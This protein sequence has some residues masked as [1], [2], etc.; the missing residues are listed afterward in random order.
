MDESA[1]REGEILAE[2]FRVERL[3]G[4]G[5]M[6][7]V[8]RA[9]D[10]ETKGHAAIKVLVTRQH[11]RRDRF[12]REASVL[13]RL[14]H[15]AIVR[16]LAHGLTA[17]QAPFLAMEWLDGEDL[18][19]RLTR[20]GLAVE[21]TLAMMHRVCDGLSAAHQLGITH[22]DVKPS[23]LFL[24]GGDVQRVKLLDFGVAREQ[25]A[26]R[27]STRAGAMVGTVGYMAPEQA[28]GAPDV[29][30]RADVFALGCVMFECLTGQPAFTGQHDIAVLA[31]VL[32][33][34]PP[35][36]S[37][38]QPSVG[39]DLD[40]LVASQLA[41]DKAQRPAD[42]R[43]VLR[44]L[45][46]VRI[47]PSP[48]TRAR[49]PAK[50]ERLS[51]AERRIVSVVL[52]RPPGRSGDTEPP[53]TLDAA[54]EERAL[55]R[56]L[57]VQVTV[58][59]GGGVLIVLGADGTRTAGDQ[60]VQAA[61][62]A[63]RLRA[64]RP[65]LTVA[66]ATGAVE[67]DAEV[68]VGAAID[69]A[70]AAIQAA[71]L[72][73]LG[74]VVDD[75][76]L[77]LL[78]GHFDHE[79]VGSCNALVI[80]REDLRSERLLLGKHM[81]CV[82]REKDLVLLEATLAECIDDSVARVVLVT[83]P[84]GIGKSR[85]GAELLERLPHNDSLRVLVARCD[86][87]FAGSAM[88]LVQRILRVALG[89]RVGDAAA[90]QAAKA[91]A[92]LGALLAPDALDTSVEFVCELL[93]LELPGPGSALLRTA[94]GNPE[95]MREQVRRALLT[96]L[97]A[98]LAEKPLV[99]LLED[100]HWADLPSITSAQELLRALADRSLFV[101]ALARPEVHERFPMLWQPLQPQELTL[102]GLTRR[103]AE[104]LVHAA[105][106]A[107]S[108]PVVARIVALAEGNAFY[109]EELIRCAAEGRTEFPVTVLAIVQRRLERLGSEE[110][111]ALR[112]ASVFG[113]TSWEGGVATL[114]G[115]SADAAG[116][117]ENLVDREIL[118]RAPHAHF[119]GEAEYVFRHAFLRDAAYAMLAPADRLTAH[120][121]A[122]AWL[123]AHGERDARVLADHFEAGGAPERALPWLARAALAAMEAADL[124][125]ALTLSR[126]GL[127]LGASGQDRGIFLL[128]AANA[129]AW[130]SEA[131]IS[132]LPEALTLLPPAS[133]H[134]W[135]AVSILTFCS[136]TLGD[137]ASAAS[138]LELT[139]ATPPGP[140]LT[141]AYGRALQTLASST[142]LIGKVE[143]GWALLSGFDAVS[144]DDPNC[145]AAFLIWRD[146]ARSHLATYA[147][148][149]GHWKLEQALAWAR[150]GAE[151]MRA[152]GSVWGEAVAMF[153]VGNALLFLG[154][155]DGAASALAVSCTLAEQSGNTLI[156]RYATFLLARVALLRGALVEAR[157]LLDRFADTKDA[158]ILHG[159]EGFGAEILLAEARHEEALAL[160]HKA[161]LGSV[162]LY[163]GMAWT[164]VA[165]AR[166]AA[167][168][169]PAAL[170]AVARARSEGATASQVEFRSLLLLTEARA[171]AQLGRHE[172]A[173][174]AL[175]EG[176]AFVHAVA[177]DITDASLRR[178]FLGMPVHAE[179]AAELG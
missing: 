39:A 84:S 104:R 138:Y 40:A 20:G 80:E 71:L 157:A 56:A 170:L 116:W 135:L 52:G 5:G 146:L 58:L 63:L 123:E 121:L 57:E 7:A 129:S 115:A 120:R 145:D 24:P 177:A 143:E 85:L 15:P 64:L 34:D 93:D 1:L 100:L 90:A 125:V 112:A 140:E 158:T 127:A 54:D 72:A 49:Q 102:Q 88:G 165:R 99:L 117:L 161:T 86:P 17:S 122:G 110:R 82:G 48:R 53:S 142:V 152:L 12:A 95:V 59:Q 21:E 79:R 47:D 19:A 139:R 106:G 144:R 16:Y 96:W 42:A 50:A 70:A 51:A 97:E 178:T 167:R 166:L 156:L 175:E 27:R 150:E 149:Q 169:A 98:E 153:F 8:Y 148:V 103:A 2:R 35:L 136:S 26:T 11:A 160:A 33:E 130:W 113:E 132:T 174:A 4:I 108:E 147:P 67:S 36:V 69:A 94:R 105:L 77:H 159:A 46:A 30:A 107:A 171:L 28:A 73:E 137:A 44:A 74:V 18:A 29:D 154:S 151:A 173:R 131:D 45:E 92:H 162:V 61:R 176:R 9:Y 65:E 60:A 87:T 83:G 168:D 41:K 22:R 101:L 13:A 126:R 134:W 118:A 66:V 155:Y 179:L 75:V 62:S 133:T 141:W 32:R 76:T 23:N 91:R 31:K 14:A 6:G 10:L 55:S 43:A 68:P 128:V 3:A 38:L 37:T 119:P 111:R 172:E 124:E 81:P 109:L 163:R 114:L 78:G 89:L 164:T 25:A